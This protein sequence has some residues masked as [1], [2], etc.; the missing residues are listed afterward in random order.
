MSWRPK[1]ELQR[2]LARRAAV[3]RPC[4]V[5]CVHRGWTIRLDGEE[6]IAAF[7][8][9]GVPIPKGKTRI[10]RKIPA[11]SNGREGVAG[12]VEGKVQP[13]EREVIPYRDQTPDE[14][15]L[16]VLLGVDD[17]MDA[18]DAYHLEI[19]RAEVA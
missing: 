2:F 5:P 18:I 13:R 15:R 7:P 16:H 8:P 9:P 4:A 14:Q 19:E 1:G 17:L 10:A 6:D 11:L 12:N 3:G